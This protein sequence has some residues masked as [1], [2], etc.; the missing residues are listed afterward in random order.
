MVFL[1][2][3]WVRETIFIH[4]NNVDNDFYY[5]QIIKEVQVYKRKTSANIMSAKA[6]LL[7]YNNH[8]E[9][10]EAYSV[11]LYDFYSLINST[12]FL[13]PSDSARSR[14]LHKAVLPVAQLPAVLRV[15][16]HKRTGSLDL[17]AFPVPSG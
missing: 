9:I 16:F 14:L 13:F 5:K 15:S 1:S 6:C 10:N 3:L 2:T 12:D 11:T 7:Q 17:P 8:W 4:Y